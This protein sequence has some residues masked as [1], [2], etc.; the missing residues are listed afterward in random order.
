MAILGSKLPSF[1]VI[2]YEVYNVEP[3]FGACDV[4]SPLTL[5]LVWQCI[6]WFVFSR[7]TGLYISMCNIVWLLVADLY[8]FDDMQHPYLYNY[9]NS[10]M[11]WKSLYCW[12][13]LPPFIAQ[14]QPLKLP[15][16]CLPG[17]IIHGLSYPNHW[18]VWETTKA[19]QWN[20]S[21]I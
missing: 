7:S 17:S 11:C 8:T 15:R 10:I 5:W 19:P 4:F 6:G 12:L 18:P 20:R 1:T 2:F 14:N 21:H 3:Q 13:G 16:Q 9:I